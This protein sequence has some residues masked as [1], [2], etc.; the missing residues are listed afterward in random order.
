MKFFLRNLWIATLIMTSIHAVV[1][2]KGNSVNDPLETF[3][4]S[5][6]NCV[7][8]VPTQT[9]FFGLDNTSGTYSL[10]K[11]TTTNTSCLGIASTTGNNPL[12]NTFVNNLALSTLSTSDQPRIICTSTTNSTTTPTALFAVN[13]SGSTVT[14]SAILNDA[15][16]TN[17]TASIV[18]VAANSAYAFAAVTTNG[19]TTSFGTGASDGIALLTIN[20]TTLALTPLNATNGTTGNQALTVTTTTTQVTPDGQAVTFATTYT[21]AMCWNETLQRLYVGLQ[22]TSAVKMMS[23]LIEIKAA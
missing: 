15:S 12:A 2:F 16:G 8:H 4:T 18:G 21:P 17:T 20:P 23:V 10:T 13:A 19:T 7:F 1:V 22:G 14:T 9:V 11:L 6:N 5:F 3:L